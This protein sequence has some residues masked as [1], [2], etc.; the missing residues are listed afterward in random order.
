VSEKDAMGNDVSHA[1]TLN[2]D[3]C[4][5][6][7]QLLGRARAERHI[8]PSYVIERLML[9]SA[10]LAGLE[11]GDSTAFWTPK[12]F[13]KAL[14][15]YAA[16][17]GVTS[18]LLD[19]VLLIA[20]PIP[21][22]PAGTVARPTARL[23]VAAGLLVCLV[24]GSVAWYYSSRLQSVWPSA[25]PDLRGTISALASVTR[26]QPPGRQAP[27]A[28]PST[29]PA[30]S[31]VTSAP[32]APDRGRV[33][34]AQTSWVFVR[35]PDNTVVER[36]LQPVESLTLRDWPI[37]LAVG[38]IGADDTDGVR[39]SWGDRTID[40]TPFKIGNEVRIR[41]PQLAALAPH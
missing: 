3:A 8:P 10:Q 27:R 39:L 37:Y 21:D 24:G 13:E 5:A 40:V 32:P 11:R 20:P 1:P 41:T 2:K 19:E 25:V 22:P 36:I 38:S 23:L 34:V 28:D 33:V 12:F 35:Y 26:T 17:L 9:S 14:R 18:P 15:K 4:R 29:S 30:A 31:V 6:V 16:L 7:G